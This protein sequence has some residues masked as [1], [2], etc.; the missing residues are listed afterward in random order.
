VQEFG[1]NANKVIRELG[2]KV[3]VKMYMILRP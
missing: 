3:D 2:M 1:V